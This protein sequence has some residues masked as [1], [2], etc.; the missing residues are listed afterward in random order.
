MSLD[1]SKLTNIRRLPDS[2][3]RSECPACVSEGHDKDR[4]HLWVHRSGAYKCSKYGDNREHSKLIYRLIAGDDSER[5]YEYY[6]PQ[7]KLTI[8]KV[9]PESSLSKL[10]PD[11]SYWIGRGVKQEVVERLGG[12]IAKE[13]ELGKLAGRYVFPL[14]NIRGQLIAFAGR[15]IGDTFAKRWKIIGKKSHVI[16]PTPETANLTDTVFLVEGIGCSA[17]AMGIGIYNTL[18]L[19][20]ISISGEQIG[21]LV[22]RGVRKIVIATNN[23]TSGV[24]NR[25]AE[26]LKKRLSR[27]FNESD[28]LIK[29][30]PKKDFLD[31]NEKELEEYKN[32]L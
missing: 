18:C 20:G 15:A 17:V 3:I 22:S 10:I 7:P 30:P 21:Y 12:G 8:D 6:D 24:G 11:Y 25:A 16:F 31:C 5:S 32:N 23:E 29:L 27:F 19:F 28:V 2:S 14:R 9:F 1:L 13:S 26:D 4:N